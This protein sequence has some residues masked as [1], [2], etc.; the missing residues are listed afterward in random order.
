MILSLFA[1]LLALQDSKFENSDYGVRLRIPPGWNIDGARQARVIAKITPGGDFLI[2]PEILVYEI[3][4]SEPITLLQYKEQL[5]H[6]LQRAFKEPRMLDDRVGEAAGRSGFCLEIQSKGNGDVDVVSIKGVFQRS[7]RR[8]IGVDAL[9]QV[10]KEGDVRK[11]YDAVLATLEFTPRKRP[12]NLEAGA[13]E[14]VDLLRTLAGPPA[15]AAAELQELGLFIGDKQVGSYR[16]EIRPGAQGAVAGD[17]FRTRTKIDMGEDGRV[18]TS[19]SGFLSHDLSVQSAEVIEVKVGKDKRTQNFSAKIAL[20]AGEVVVERRINGEASRAR[21]AVPAGTI[22]SELAELLQTRLT[23]GQKRLYL[24]P[25][26]SAF[27][28]E[29]GALKIEISGLHK[30]KEGELTS[31][32]HVSHLVRD[33]GGIMTYWHGIDRSLQ[34][35][36]AANQSF[37]I[38]RLK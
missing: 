19:T 33:E 32:V 4:F 30:M 21:F 11:T 27:E 22:L 3:P 7:P 10:G 34:R 5:R 37:V 26:A 8:M 29:T 28:D 18:E 25:M 12:D 17:E 35:V 2:R 36:S 15:P 9:F 14:V 13:K 24:L 23:G 1:S 16:V 20:A 38:R 6:Y 31:D